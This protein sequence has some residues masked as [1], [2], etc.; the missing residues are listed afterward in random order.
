[1][2][3]TTTI[4]KQRL[5]KSLPFGLP[6]SSPFCAEPEPAQILDYVLEFT[7]VYQSF[8]AQQTGRRELACVCSYPLYYKLYNLTS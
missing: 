7:R 5:V 3:S 6:I 2:T 1:M 4:H 8:P